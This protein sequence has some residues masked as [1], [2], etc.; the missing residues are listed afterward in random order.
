MRVGWL[1]DPRRRK[2]LHHHGFPKNSPV[3]EHTVSFSGNWTLSKCTA[4][5]LK[6]PASWLSHDS[7]LEDAYQLALNVSSQRALSRFQRLGRPLVMAA[8]KKPTPPAGPWW[9]WNY[10]SYTDKSSEVWN[11]WQ[12]WVKNH[13]WPCI[14]PSVHPFIAP[15][16][17]SPCIH[18]YT[19]TCIHRYTFV[20]I[21]V[22]LYKISVI[23]GHIFALIS[24]TQHLLRKLRPKWRFIKV[25][26][27]PSLLQGLL[28]PCSLR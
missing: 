5:D 3:F 7:G 4:S 25:N 26:N 12:V 13:S 22:Y 16:S 10:L 19:H 21:H 20:Y 23:L 11:F 6:S 14:H 24:R 27:W 15:S 18:A 17:L 28:M 2:R 8:D 9:I 1:A